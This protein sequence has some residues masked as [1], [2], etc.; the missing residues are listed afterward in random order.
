VQ[1]KRGDRQ[2]DGHGVAVSR[3]RGAEHAQRRSCWNVPKDEPTLPFRGPAP[4]VRARTGCEVFGAVRFRFDREWPWGVAA[5]VAIACAWLLDPAGIVETAREGAFETIGEL[6]PRVRASEPVVVVDIDRES[7]ARMGSWP[8]RRKL[9]A[10]LVAKSA[11]EGPRAIAIDV[12]LS[13]EDR[14]G[15]AGLA[16]ELA[17]MSGRADLPVSGF[18]DDDALLANE[19]ATTGNVVLGLVLDN[20]GTDAAPIPAQLAVEGTTEGIEPRSAAGLLAPYEPLAVG[21]AGIGVLSFQ[22][23]PLGRVTGAPVLALAGGDVF[24]GF[25]LETLRVVER[26]STLILKNGPNRI[27]AGPVEVPF[28]NRAEMRLH[29]SAAGSWAA[30]T[31]PAW[32]ILSDIGSGNARLAGKIVLIG[33]SAPEAGAFLPVAGTT[34]MPTVQIQAEAIEQMLDGRFLTR[35]STAMWWELSAMVLLGLAAVI[36]A[37]RLSPALA[38]LAALG[39]AACWLAVTA[40]AFRRAGMLIDPIGPAAATIIAANVAGFAGFVRTRTLKTAIQSKFERYVPP[41]VVARL[42][43]E[44]ESLK[45]DGELRE[46]TALL[47]DVEGFTRMTETSDPHTVVRTMDG[48]FDLVTEL[49]VSHGGM[50]DKIVGD[51]VLA[52]FNIP[53]PLAD[54][55]DAALRCAQAIIASTNEFRQRPDTAA[56]GFGRTRCG[57]EAGVAV[58]GDVGGRRRLDYTAYGAVVNKAVRFEEANKAL[59]S[60]ICI[61]AIAAGNLKSAWLLRRLGRIEVRGM[62]GLCDVYEPWSEEV[63]E[64]VRA[65]YAEAVALHETEPV[66]A[67]RLF[68]N[69]AARLPGDAVIGMWLERLAA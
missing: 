12:L 8:W 2:S 66:R 43:R 49:V 36:L 18:E 54:H 59:R 64:E 63:P 1:R 53:A 21:A 14:K 44:P 56:M 13:G 55:T 17:R 35:P 32:E 26:A 33:A 41:E 23:G 34:L 19:F 46:V 67:R 52:F 60:S 27:D 30:R 45:L 25:A 9:F 4:G 5:V 58:V 29:L 11:A 51:A 38:A 57:I 6:L 28:D 47:C 16:K 22:A 65:E 40:I 3:K 48:Y 24:A 31:V 10:D 42:V 15:P 7:L 37:I 20:E 50:V 62:E 39:L 69:L 61:G 68:A